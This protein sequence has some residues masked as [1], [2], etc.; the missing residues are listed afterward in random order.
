[1][2]KLFIILIAITSIQGFAQD[3]ILFEADYSKVNFLEVVDSVET[4]DD[5]LTDISKTNLSVMKVDD[6][7]VAFA[8]Y[9]GD[10]AVTVLES[11]HLHNEAWF[12]YSF[13][14]NISISCD[15]NGE[16]IM[17]EYVDGNVN[18]GAGYF[19]NLSEAYISNEDIDY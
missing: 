13:T 8:I 12:G 18:N 7:Y 5:Y 10:T 16:L 17:Y 19:V 11:F 6:K 4:E 15:E 14:E 9:D 3:R 2:K 1:M